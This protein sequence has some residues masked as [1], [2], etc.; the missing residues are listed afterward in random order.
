[1]VPYVKLQDL[2]AKDSGRGSYTLL[3]EHMGC[4]NGCRCGISVY[5]HK[6]YLREDIWETEKYCW[7]IE[8][9]KPID[10]YTM[11]HYSIT[12]KHKEMLRGLMDSAVGVTKAQNDVYGMFLEEMDGYVQGNKDLD[13]CC[14]IL[15]NRVSLYL[16]EQS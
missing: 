12:D 11:L 7:G 4:V 14:E 1:M 5:R 10:G 6:E 13:G 3:D 16:A 8:F 9:E 15:Q 2:E